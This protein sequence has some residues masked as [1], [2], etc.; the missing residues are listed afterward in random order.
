MSFRFIGGAPPNLLAP[1]ATPPPARQSRRG[2]TQNL[3]LTGNAL[4]AIVL[5]NEEKET[6][7]LKH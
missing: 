1:K 3:A 4:L 2:A 7:F 5:S 6:S